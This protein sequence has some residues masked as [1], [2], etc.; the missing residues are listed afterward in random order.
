MRAPEK[1][2]MWMSSHIHRDAF[3]AYRYH[4]RSDAHSK[5]LCLNVLEDLLENCALLRDQAERRS[6]VYGI[7]VEVRTSPGKKK[8]LDLAIGTPSA[9][10]EFGAEP[11]ARAPIGDL[12]FSC[13]AKSC[14]TQ[15]VG[16]KPRLYDELSSSHEIVHQ[17]WPT[18]IATG[19]AVVNVASSFVSSLRQ[20]PGRPPVVSVH[21]QPAA[22][23]AMIEHLRGL[24][25]RDDTRSVGF[26]AY[27]TI[28]IDCDNRG[29]V[30]LSTDPP[31]P[32]P[33]DP[34]EYETYVRRV[35]SFWDAR[36]PDL[37]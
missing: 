21:K 9:A 36:F 3:G 13:E 16:S 5:Q 14:M 31:A 17:G 33:G 34:D 27:S 11:I 1:F 22:A 12:L 24:S 7:N 32:Q 6:I 23:A 35:C 2:A 30:T 8:K 10:P 26:E 29:P 28:V 20:R 37:P 15:H 4:P 19:I 18:A 25:F